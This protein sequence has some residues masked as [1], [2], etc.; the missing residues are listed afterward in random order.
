MILISLEYVESDAILISIKE[1]FKKTILILE[2][3]PLIY[4]K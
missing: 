2:M 3:V 4:I 1:E